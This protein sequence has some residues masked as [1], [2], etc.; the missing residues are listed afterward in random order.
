[1]SSPTGDEDIYAQTRAVF[2]SM[3]P[4]EPLTTPEVAEVLDLDRRTVYERLSTLA[5]EGALETKKV[6]SGGRVWWRPPDAAE[7]EATEH[8]KQRRQEP[9]QDKDE[10]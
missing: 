10:T 1:M 8:H 6:G 4:P 2:S 5:D 7:G 3:D 9:G